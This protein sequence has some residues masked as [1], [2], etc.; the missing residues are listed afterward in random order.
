M[1]G[2]FAEVGV[3]RGDFSRKILEICHPSKLY[4]IDRWQGTCDG[5]DSDENYRKVLSDCKREIDSGIVKILKGDSR[6]CLQGLED[7]SLDFCYLDTCH[8][9]LVPHSELNIVKTK[10]KTDGL[11][12]GHDYCNR[13][14]SDG[15][16]YGV[17][18]AV[19]EFCCTEGWEMKY[20][21]MELH[22][23]SSYAL[24]KK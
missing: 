16:M 15:S 14:L 5:Y 21:T 18:N 6:E 4:L 1:G 3:F 23:H 13:A 17:K 19:N 11:I 20:L 9:Y 2:V 12:C 10:I 24:Q 22:G 8:D 7:C